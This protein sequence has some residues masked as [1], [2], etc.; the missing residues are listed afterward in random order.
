MRVTLEM[1]E[2]PGS[3][4]GA[5]GRPASFGRV[6]VGFTLLY[7]VCV[8]FFYSAWLYG[9]PGNA[10]GVFDA[11]LNP[12]ITVGGAVLAWVAARRPDRGHWP[13]FATGCVCLAAALV[14]VAV[15]SWRREVA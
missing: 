1:R 9:L 3:V 6:V 4:G 11:V 7:A 12:A 10:V 5:A 15:C 14:I 2:A 8:M 13:L